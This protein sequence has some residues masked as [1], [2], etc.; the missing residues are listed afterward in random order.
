MNPLFRALL[1]LVAAVTIADLWGW[2]KS[3]RFAIIADMDQAAK[4]A[5]G[6]VKR[7]QSHKI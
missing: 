7:C 2:K 5:D 6:R 3:H 1:V 4:Q